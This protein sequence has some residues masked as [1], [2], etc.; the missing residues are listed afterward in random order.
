MMDELETMKIVA[1]AWQ[2]Q[3]HILLDQI[4]ALTIRAGIDEREPDEAGDPDS[5][6]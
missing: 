4:V 2:Q 3:A 6:G 1:A 5:E